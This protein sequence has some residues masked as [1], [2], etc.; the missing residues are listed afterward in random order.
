MSDSGGK[1]KTTQE[2]S[3][4]A[5]RLLSTKESNDKSCT[6]LFLTGKTVTSRRKQVEMWRE[7][8][9]RKRW[10]QPDFENFE[11]FESIDF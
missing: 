10:P 8:G 4:K 5:E 1:K 11:Y 6:Q 9:E 7:V 3:F 2:L